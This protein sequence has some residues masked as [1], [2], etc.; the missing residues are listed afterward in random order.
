MTPERV[1]RIYPEP[2]RDQI[3]YVFDLDGQV[4]YTTGGLLPA[5]V[6]PVGQWVSIEGVPTAVNSALRVSP[7]LIEEAEYNW[8][9]RALKINRVRK[10]TEA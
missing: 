7:V 4:H 9:D 5:G 10:V 3:Q 8:A 6:L 2:T 1:L